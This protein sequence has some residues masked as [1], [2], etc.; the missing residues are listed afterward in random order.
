MKHEDTSCKT[1]VHILSKFN[2]D[3]HNIRS[4]RCIDDTML[5][6]HKHIKNEGRPNKR[7]WEEKCSCY[8]GIKCQW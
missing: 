4:I 1:T 6:E 8:T 3:R 7:K 2:I 5:S